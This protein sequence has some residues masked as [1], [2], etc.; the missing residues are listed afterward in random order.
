MGTAQ[1]PGD[2][3]HRPAVHRGAR[4]TSA[5][6]S[7]ASCRA[8]SS[9]PRSQKY[10]LACANDRAD[11]RG[12]HAEDLLRDHEAAPGRVHGQPAH[13]L[14]RVDG[15]STAEP[16]ADEAGASSDETFESGL[17]NA[18]QGQRRA[19]PARLATQQVG[20]RSDRVTAGEH[21]RGAAAVRLPGRRPLER[22]RRC[23]LHQAP[24]RRRG[25]G[26]QGRGAGG[27][28]A[29]PLVGLRRGS[30]RPAAT[31]RCSR[32]CPPRSRASIADPDDHDDVGARAELLRAGRRGG[33]VE[34]IA[35]RRAAPRS[36]RRRCAAHAPAPDRHL[37]HPVRAGGSVER[38]AGDRVHAA[39][40]VGRDRRAGP[41]RR[42]TG[43]R[44]PSAVR[45]ASGSPAPTRRSA[46]WCRGAR[47]RRW[48]RRAGRRVDARD[49]GD[50]PHVLPGDATSTWSDDR[51]ASGRCAHRRRAWQ[52]TSDGLVGV[53]VGTGQQWLDFC[54]MVG[55][56]EWMEDR[57]LF[58]ERARTSPRRSTAWMAEH[59]VG[60]GARPGRLVP[61][62][63][64]T[65]RRTARRSPGIEHFQ[66]AAIVR[67]Q[68]AR[69]LRR[70][71]SAV[72][73]PPARSARAR[74][75]AAPRRAHSTD[76]TGG[77]GDRRRADPRSAVSGSAPGRWP[78][79]GLR[80][81]DMTAFWAGPLVH[82]TCSRCSA[83]R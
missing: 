21:D 29:A 6:S 23:V 14:A 37:D 26:R 62:P 39:G 13:R 20:P 11:R 30:D 32:S 9:R 18:R 43:R 61:D 24:G 75:G 78:F 8:T 40:L 38:P 25:R 56:P 57:S 22:D 52:A 17:N 71:R 5:T 48:R 64:R 51:S 4:C 16:D 36:S 81:L 83:P 67:R 33:V 73:V 15:R 35:P 60:R 41:R 59:T 28:P 31:A 70:T 76:R 46:R 34:G 3:L 58:A 80:V 12:L 63:A 54:V 74:A 69:R 47:A 79:S 45:S 44:S 68:P 50:V 72:P 77:R 66:A 10:A 49:A 7:T 53:G 19:V 42:R 65:D 27:R 1:V 55:H 2:G 82:A